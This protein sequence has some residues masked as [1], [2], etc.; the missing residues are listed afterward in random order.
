[1]R[2]YKIMRQKSLGN[3]S[4]DRRDDGWD[5]SV[6]EL[7]IAVE[8]VRS[9]LWKKRM[10]DHAWFDECLYLSPSLA[11]IPSIISLLLV[12]AGNSLVSI[13]RP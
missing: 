11:T 1:M 6:S 10:I 5:E 2:A 13:E 3:F 12:A 4:Y 7:G 8:W 9:N